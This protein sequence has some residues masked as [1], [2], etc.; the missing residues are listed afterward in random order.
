MQR[1]FGTLP[2][3]R[4][5]P[6]HVSNIVG[7][8]RSRY[9]KNTVNCRTKALRRILREIGPLCANLDLY[10]SVPRVGRARPPQQRV[11]EE[12]RVALLQKMPMWLRCFVLFCADLGLRFNTARTVRLSLY[13]RENRTIDFTTK[14]EA[15][16]ILPLSPALVA[17]LESIPKDAGDIPVLEALYGRLPHKSTVRKAFMQAC[18]R[19]G[20]PQAVTP[21]TFRRTIVSNLYR[22]TKDLR[23]CQQLL[24]HA[25][26]ATTA[27]YLLD[28][29]PARLRELLANLRPYTEVKQ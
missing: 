2:P 17:I 7:G 8:W 27:Y 3:A 12:Q 23:A 13:N 5:L 16:Q 4:L 22:D 19:A 14:G 20:L 9:A 6:V 25:N 15:K 24:G 29:D 18:K 21:H 11:T 1:L 10:R 28:E 26:L